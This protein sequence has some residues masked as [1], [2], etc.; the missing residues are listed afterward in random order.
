[1]FRG[2]QSMFAYC[3]NLYSRLLVNV[4]ITNQQIHTTHHACTPAYMI[5][6]QRIRATLV[7]KGI[8]ARPSSVLL[9]PADEEGEGKLHKGHNTKGGH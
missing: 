6:L 4:Y 3:S 9:S 1:M 8:L 7:D 5:K 2:I